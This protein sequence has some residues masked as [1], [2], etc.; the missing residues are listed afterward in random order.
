M[1]VGFFKSNHKI[2]AIAIFFVTL[3][4]WVPSFWNDTLINVPE[5]ALLADVKKLGEIKWLNFLVATLYLSMQA[6]Y[7]NYIANRYR[8][9]QT[10]SYIVALLFVVFNSASPSFLVFNPIFIVNTFLLVVLHQL[11][12]VYNQEKVFSSSFNTGLLL[13]LAALTYSPT[14]I[15]FPLIWFALIYLKTSLWRE[16]IISL[17]GFMVPIL[18]YVTYCFFTDQLMELIDKTIFSSAIFPGIGL[19]TGSILWNAYFYVLIIIG[20]LAGVNFLN[21]INRSVVKIKK[22]TIV[23]LVMFLLLLAT[24]FINGYDFVAVYLM[25]TIPLAVIIA[26][27]FAEIK[28]QWLAE[29]FF[30]LLVAAIITSYFS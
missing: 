16:F 1:L 9:I 2:I 30:A 17:F 20:L 25:M 4:L 29:L 14:I 19:L 10:P 22:L 13:S 23:V 24:I 21:Y 15:V 12:E 28:R 3:M 5:N 27:Y 26:N 8:L 7:L 6:I 11:F 18:F